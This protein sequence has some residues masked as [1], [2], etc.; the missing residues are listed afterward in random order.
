MYNGPLH[1]TDF[2][3]KIL[4]INNNQLDDETYKTRKRIEGMLTLAV[5]EVDAPFYFKPEKVSSVLKCQVPPLKVITAG[6]GHLGFDASLT[7]CTP[8]AIKTNADWDT[9]WALFKEYI[10]QKAPNDINK[11]GQNTAGYKI[12]TNENLK[13]LEVSFESNQLSGKIEKLRRL[14][15]TRFQENP[16]KNWGPKAKPQ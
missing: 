1:N 2:I 3:N 16:T 14:K 11:L 6:L 12:L 10:K 5:N 15:I 9:I 8:S 4:D 7:H 13:P